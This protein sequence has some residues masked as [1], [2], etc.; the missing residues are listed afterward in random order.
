[1]NEF[2][3]DL[4]GLPSRT[5]THKE[6]KHLGVESKLSR[7]WTTEKKEKESLDRGRRGENTKK[8]QETSHQMFAHFLKTSKQ[9]NRSR[10]SE[11]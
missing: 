10:N 11:K 8:N 2:E 5:E 9:T 4:S 7:I 3:I 1:M 6:E